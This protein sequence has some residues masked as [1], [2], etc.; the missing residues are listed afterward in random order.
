MP[1]FTMC[2]NFD[3]PVR[4]SCYRYLAVPSEYRQ[5]YRRFEY[6][7]GQCTEYVPAANK[8]VRT[9]EEA[10]NATK[11]VKEDDLWTPV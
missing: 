4:A 2:T 5:S 11:P 6:A 9:I 10:D 3:C 7:F 8:L 1:D